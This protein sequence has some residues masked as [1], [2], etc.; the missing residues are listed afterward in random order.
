MASRRVRWLDLSIDLYLSQ[1]K[2][3]EYNIRQLGSKSEATVWWRKQYVAG[4]Y[5]TSFSVLLER[6]SRGRIE[7]PMAVGTVGGVTSCTRWRR[8]R[9]RFSKCGMRTSWRGFAP[10]SDSLQKIWARS[11]HSRPSESC[12]GIW[13]C[14][15]RTWRLPRAPIRGNFD[16]QGSID[17]AASAEKSIGISVAQQILSELRSGAPEPA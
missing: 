1:S 3:P 11:W 15:P 16:R 4:R 8:L 14:M 6:G 9:S 2:L 12:A 13:S 17:R 5:L 10:R 7:V